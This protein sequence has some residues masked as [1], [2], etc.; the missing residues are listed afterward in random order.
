MHI[1]DT[2]ILV[3]MLYFALAIQGIK[4][5]ISYANRLKVDNNP[6]VETVTNTQAPPGYVNRKTPT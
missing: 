6:V 2:V 4:K 1:K 3:E 5:N